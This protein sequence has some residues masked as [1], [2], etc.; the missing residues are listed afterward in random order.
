MLWEEERRKVMLAFWEI[1]DVDF[2][3][4]VWLEGSYCGYRG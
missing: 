1:I 2:S 3:I 4:S